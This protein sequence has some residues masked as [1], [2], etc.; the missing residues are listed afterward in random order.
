M[1]LY[2][3]VFHGNPAL[4]IHKRLLSHD[5]YDLLIAALRPAVRTDHSGLMG[6][7]LVT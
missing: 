3:L 6:D 4:C 2:R 5:V 7:R 1:H